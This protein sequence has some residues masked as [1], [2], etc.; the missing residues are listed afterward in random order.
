MF[1]S[2][3]ALVAAAALAAPAMADV[4]SSFHFR[5][6]YNASD[7]SSLEG[8]RRVHRQLLVDATDACRRTPPSGQRGVDRACRNGL[9]EEAVKRINNAL[10]TKIHSG[11]VQVAHN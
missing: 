3:S 10:L 1:K 9:V 11:N 2:L 5:F 8:A 6:T 4:S 7:L